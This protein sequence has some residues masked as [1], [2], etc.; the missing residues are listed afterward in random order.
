MEYIAVFDIGT[1]AIKGV[2][3]DRNSILHGEITFELH[4]FHGAN[5]EVE[6]DPAE[7]WSGIQS[8][9]NQW[10]YKEGFKPSQV[11]LVTFSGQME[12]VIPLKQQEGRA[13]LY[14]D[15]RAQ[16]QAEKVKLRLPE[17]S[18][19]TGNSINPST[20]LA[21]LLWL[22]EH[23]E[24]NL[25]DAEKYVFSAKDYIIYKLTGFA[26]SDPVTAAT[27]GMMNIKTRE[28]DERITGS[29]EVSNILPTLHNPEEAVG[30]VTEKAAISTGFYKDTPVLCG[31]GDAGASTMGAGAVNEGDCYLYLGTTGWVAVSMMESSP[32][33]H[34]VF[35]LAHLPVDFHISI[36]PLLNAGNVHKW[37]ID[38]FVDQKED[39]GYSEFEKLILDSAP[40]S[41]GLLFLPYVHGERCPINDPE[42]KGAFW[43]INP[44][45]TKSDFL[46]SVL[47]GL[48]FSLRQT[49]EL[50]LQDGK[51]D[52]TLIGGGSKSKAWC[53][54][55]AD[56]LGM[57]VKVPKDGEFLPSIGA[58][59]TG[60][61]HLGWVDNYQQ[62]ADEYINGKDSAVYNPNID[63]KETYNS[64]YEKFQK[65][66]PGLKGVS[67]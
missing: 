1:T 60:F 57:S 16:S 67:L 5:G 19:I 43:G 62:F 29:F 32:K 44:K 54:C 37:A 8:I 42:A 49:L 59:A 33:E 2:L 13:I 21:K 39:L 34:G 10:F 26:A 20:P 6:Q 35:T 50:L 24:T 4:T 56:V 14:S 63:V 27:T 22:R 46:R 53:Q 45:T 3:V 12:D 38:T 28:W 65:I 9:T 61:V 51:G 31:C 41:G 25:L 47:E 23:Q 64:L 7:W 30:P 52:I 58:A 55:L 66:Y 18:S 40:G 17:I 48:S 11:K 15:T 36:A